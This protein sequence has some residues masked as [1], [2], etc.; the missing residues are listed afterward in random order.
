MP[1]ALISRLRLV[2][3]CWIPVAAAI[4][5]FDLLRQTRD[6][7]S[8]GAGRPFGDDFINFFSGPYLAWHGRAAE[9][10][11]W[12]AFHAFEVSLAGPSLGFYHYSYPPALLLVSV[13]LA[14]VGYLPGFF[15]WV[16]GGWLAF[17]RA[18]ALIASNRTALLF[19]LA[20]PAVFIN[21]VNG[22]T[23]TWTAALF[24]GGLALLNRRPAVAGVLF[25]LL[26]CK[27]QL[28]ILLPV[29][30]AAGR[31]WR[32]FIAAA[33]TVLILVGASAILFGAD[34][35]PAYFKHAEV[36]R[37]NVLESGEGVWHRMV[38]VYVA[39]RR[40]G[41]DPAAAYLVQAAVALP[42][43]IVVALAWFRDAPAAA[44]YALLVLGTW[45][46]TPYLQDYDLVIGAF[47]VLWLR[48]LYS[49]LPCPVLISAGLV[50]ILPFIAAAL[51]NLTGFAFGPL[52]I[53]PAFIIAA[54]A[55]LVPPR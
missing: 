21:S 24:G 42:V 22:Q 30:L 25:G 33:L 43:V 26:I 6:G 36:L 35:W 1:H 10:Y 55:A 28:G 47:V 5:L 51:A 31:Q 23:G 12:S 52:F 40:L 37:H 19:S 32:A 46:A 15:V 50:L 4:Y 39:A 45:L 48:E 38:S 49:D 44:R 29:A 17:Y 14:F 53:A 27:P 3:L 34:I 20:T 7:L 16:A 8:D 9:V 2:A 54:R 13:P 41:L 18:L 11:D